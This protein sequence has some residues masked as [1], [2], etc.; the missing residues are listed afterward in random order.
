MPPINPKQ[1]TGKRALFLVGHYH[2][3]RKLW[4]GERNKTEV[5]I[6][7]NLWLMTKLM[8][9]IR[10]EKDPFESIIYY[11]FDVKDMMDS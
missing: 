2:P 11:L 4:G 7:T 8:E 6:Y 10:L 1:A 5:G 3:N 9:S